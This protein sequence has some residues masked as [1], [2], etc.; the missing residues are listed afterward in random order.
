MLPFMQYVMDL[1]ESGQSRQ[2]RLI[3]K[4]DLKN[5]CS[6]VCQDLLRVCSEGTSLIARLAYL[7]YSPPSTVLASSHPI[8]S[9]TGIQQG[10]PLGPVLFAMAVDEVA[11]SLSAK[12]NIWYLGDATL[13]GPAE[14]VFCYLFCGRT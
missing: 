7:A 8:C 4:L 10:D 9:T 6:T 2:N 13:G 11:S 14:S 1:I 12:I 5:T 3:A